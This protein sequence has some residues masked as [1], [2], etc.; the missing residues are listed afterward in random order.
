MNCR[1][2]AL[3]TGLVLLVAVALLAVTAAGSMT[4]QQHQAA[5]F[6]G[7]HRG[8]E[9]AAAAESYAIAWLFSRADTER[10]PRCMENCLLPA[11]IQPDTAVP[12]HPEFE[13][14]AWWQ[15]NGTAAGRH[16]LSGEPIGYSF[17]SASESLWL[18]EEIHYQPSGEPALEETLEGVAYYRIFS[19]GQGTHP[20]STTVFETFV[21][22]PWGE[23]IQPL[24]FPPSG[25]L[26]EFCDQFST[27]L[28]CGI[29]SW[30]QRR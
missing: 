18:I 20:G 10:Q 3:V 28:A 11:G 7:K 16:P 29:Q 9:N 25:P 8:K 15:S 4:L 26:R 30:R 17:S 5:N 21:A 27:D 14:T 23:N 12:D 22:R 24:Q 13:S 19:R 1:G 6:T 2:M